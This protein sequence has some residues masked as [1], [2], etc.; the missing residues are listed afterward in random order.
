MSRGSSPPGLWCV[1]PCH[2]GLGWQGGRT[3][4]ALEGK[5]KEEE[6]KAAKIQADFDAAVLWSQERDKRRRK[7]KKRRRKLPKSSPS[8]L[9]PRAVDT[10]KSVSSSTSP[11]FLQLLVR[12]SPV[13]N[14]FPYSALGLV[15][16][17]IQLYVRGF[18]TISYFST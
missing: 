1:V 7:R 6:E 12:S 11:W 14:R 17:W 10:W 8:R 16:Q 3:T 2:A 4:S 9:A 5:R 18:R 15:R 13:E